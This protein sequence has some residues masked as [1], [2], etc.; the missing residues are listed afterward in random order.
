MDLH[1]QVVVKIKCDYFRIP[2]LWK[3][4]VQISALTVKSNIEHKH[5]K[6]FLLVWIN[7]L[8]REDQISTFSSY[9]DLSLIFLTLSEQLEN[10]CHRKIP[11][12]YLKWIILLCCFY[13]KSL[14]F[15][16]TDNFKIKSKL[17]RSRNAEEKILL[18][19]TCKC[20][21]HSKLIII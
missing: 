9:C 16:L 21:L 18:Y 20:S 5:W 10:V 15:F 12:V 14:I 4:Y 8:M 11:F 2:L 13:V 3:C 17:T 1:A 19:S 6:Y 7:S